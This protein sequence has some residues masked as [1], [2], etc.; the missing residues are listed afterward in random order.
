M[1]VWIAYRNCNLYHVG[2]KAK[3]LVHIK[4]KLEIQVVAAVCVIYSD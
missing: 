3:A 2:I 1:S 4:G